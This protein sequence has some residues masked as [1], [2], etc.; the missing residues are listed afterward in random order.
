MLLI[1]AAALSV[2]VS[3]QSRTFPLSLTDNMAYFSVLG[4][5]S[6]LKSV[7]KIMREIDYT[8]GT[9]RNAVKVKEGL[10]FCATDANI[11]TKDGVITG[12]KV[13][14]NSSGIVK[15]FVTLSN[16]IERTISSSEIAQRKVLLSA[17]L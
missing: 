13:L 2:S 16:G 14:T 3:A 17:N 4:H 11:S 7:D 15:V 6:V 12:V 10:L 5:T 8:Y 9:D 1:L